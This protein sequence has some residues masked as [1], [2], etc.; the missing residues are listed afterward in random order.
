MNVRG[1]I[2]AAGR[3]SRMGRFTSQQPKCLSQVRGKSLLSRAVATMQEAGVA[4]IAVVTGYRN[5]LLAP[6]GLR[7]FHNAE[8]ARS[9]M[10]YS[11]IH[12]SPWLMRDDCIVSYG[13]IFYRPSAVK[14]LM[15]TPADI[16]LTYDPDW[17]RLWSM[18][19]EDPL[20]DAETFRLRSDGTI[21]EIGGKPTVVS[22]VEGQ[23]MGLLK[24]TPTGWVQVVQGAHD[25]GLKL[26]ETSMTGMLQQLIL[27]QSLQV[28][29][30]MYQDG[31]GEVDTEADL[32]IYE[33]NG[34]EWL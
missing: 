30:V 31:W 21:S 33:S 2:L 18:R 22:E 19:A 29:G 5:D 15:E 24:F 12:A 16:A 23:Y 3:G 11:L 4:D 27:K 17:L 28:R 34:P 6:F 25:V 14:S 32:A 9:N 1:I 13:D 7:E 10:V 20:A 8:W 26:D